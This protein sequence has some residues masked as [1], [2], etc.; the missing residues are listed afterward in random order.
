ME[1]ETIL[2]YLASIVITAVSVLGVIWRSWITP[3]KKE[4]EKL[5]TWRTGVERDIQDIR[6][7]SARNMEWVK[8]EFGRFS[9][10][11]SKVLNKE[12]RIEHQLAT[13]NLHLTELRTKMG[14]CDS[15][16]DD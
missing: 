3:Q 4:T 9:S 16:H 10:D 6:K 7:D 1:Q 15:T 5:L 14:R 13:M 12:D 2:K 8:T 11:L